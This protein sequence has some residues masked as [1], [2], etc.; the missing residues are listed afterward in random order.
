MFYFVHQATRSSKELLH[1][2]LQVAFKK[3]VFKNRE[4]CSCFLSNLRKKGTVLYYHYHYHHHYHYHYHYHVVVV[5]IVKN[6]YYKW[7][8]LCYRENHTKISGWHPATKIFPLLCFDIHLN[9]LTGAVS[10]TY[11]SSKSL[12]CQISKPP[13]KHVLCLRFPSNL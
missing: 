11:Y 4:K 8:V 10:L 9:H 2:L 1:V 13:F 3:G 7:L 12:I 6:N 5:V